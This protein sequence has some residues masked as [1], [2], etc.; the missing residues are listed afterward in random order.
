MGDM[1]KWLIKI[2]IGALVSLGLTWTSGK[3]MNRLLKDVFDDDNAN[4]DKKG[5]IEVQEKDY[6]VR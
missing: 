6:E 1:T 3:M 2:G 5:Q 4:G